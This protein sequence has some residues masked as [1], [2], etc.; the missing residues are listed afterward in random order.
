MIENEE[1][2]EDVFMDKLH[3]YI[4]T[5]VEKVKNNSENINL[6]RIMGN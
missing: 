5:A 6:L 2:T 3:S 4:K 1:T